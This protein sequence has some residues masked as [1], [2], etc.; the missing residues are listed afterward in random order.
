MHGRTF[1]AGL[2]RWRGVLTLAG[3]LLVGSASQ[4]QNPGSAVMERGRG[5]S[6][7]AIAAQQG[8][9]GYAFNHRT[10]REAEAAARAQCDRTAGRT[11]TCEVRTTFNRSCAAMAI[12]NFGEWGTASGLTTAAAGKAA[13][14]QC[15]SHLPT[16]PC[17]VVVSAC[18]GR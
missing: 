6:W 9:Y 16:E 17:K 7:G 4:A 14:A 10:Q 15:E 12:G 8:W 2:K 1:A 13:M 3:C 5:D 11:G 18:S